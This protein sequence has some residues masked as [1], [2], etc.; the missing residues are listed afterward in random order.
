VSPVRRVAR[1]LLAAVF[2]HSGVDVLRNP[3][4]RAE[5]AAPVAARLAESLPLPSDPEQLVKINA[6]AQLVAGSALAVGRAPR[7]AATVLAGSL[8]P[9]TLAGHRFW[10]HE[11]PKRSQ[12]RV[13]FL[14][15]AG[16]LG[17][18]L[19]AIV[20]TGGAPSLTWRARRAAGRARQRV[21]G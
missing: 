14:K 3:R 9:T 11:E 2:V 6:A 4:P 16:L 18:L 19:L 1:P 10:E 5:L 8:V 17:G 20:D 7:L 13:H 15:N 21:S 12:Q